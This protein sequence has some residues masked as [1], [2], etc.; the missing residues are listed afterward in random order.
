MVRVQDLGARMKLAHD[1]GENRDST[2]PPL[3]EKA[4]DGPEAAGAVEASSKESGVHE[5]A[6]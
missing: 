3:T 4:V 2:Q 1:N 6:K 5:K